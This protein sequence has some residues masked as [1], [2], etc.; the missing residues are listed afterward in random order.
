MKETVLAKTRQFEGFAADWIAAWNG[1]DIDAIM[2]HYAEDVTVKSPFLAEAVPGSGGTVTGRETLREIYGKAFKKY[3]Q[4]HFELLRVLASTQSLV[5][6]YK[7]V[8]NLLAAET[9]VLGEDGKATLVLC[10]YAV[11]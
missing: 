7:S 8:E 5:I 11:T 2:S 6:H 4:L 3:P 10:H 9:F 1:H